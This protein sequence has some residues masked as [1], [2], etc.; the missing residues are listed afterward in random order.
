[1]RGGG[2]IL[3]VLMVFKALSCDG[4]LF[5]RY[6]Y[7]YG[8]SVRGVDVFKVWGFVYL[9]LLRFRAKRSCSTGTGRG[10]LQLFCKMF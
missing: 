5:Q 10:V 3:M 6:G 2:A 7:I 9:R 4:T 1:M 8:I